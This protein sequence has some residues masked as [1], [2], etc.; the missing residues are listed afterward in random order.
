MPPAGT[1]K[2]I[3]GVVHRNDATGTQPRRERDSNRLAHQYLIHISEPTRHLSM[4]FPPESCSLLKVLPA[5]ADTCVSGQ[6]MSELNSPQ[7]A[8][9]EFALI[10]RW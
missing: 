1:S 6:P 10:A 2:T 5:T 4:V 7:F 9:T 8:S 3:T